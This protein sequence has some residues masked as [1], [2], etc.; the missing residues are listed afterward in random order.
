MAAVSTNN[1]GRQGSTV[2]PPP[3]RTKGS[4]K[5]LGFGPSRVVRNSLPCHRHYP[6]PRSGLRRRRGLEIVDEFVDTGVSGAKSSRPARDLL[7]EA[8]GLRQVGP[9]LCWRLDRRGSQ[10]TTP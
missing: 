8:D 10:S 6:L 3:V 9:V 7:L 2:N 1:E 5:F 4:H